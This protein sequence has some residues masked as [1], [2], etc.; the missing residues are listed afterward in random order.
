LRLPSAEAP[1]RVYGQGISPAMFAMSR[2]NAF[3]HDMEAGI[4]LGDS[5]RRPAFAVA[6]GRLGALDLATGN[7]I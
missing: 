2:T 4:A 5:M 6:D 7:P 1:L 3:L